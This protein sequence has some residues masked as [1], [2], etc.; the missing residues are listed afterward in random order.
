VLQG[1]CDGFRFECDG[2]VSVIF[3]LGPK[4]DFDINLNQIPDR[5]DP[6]V[7]SCQRMVTNSSYSD[8]NIETNRS[9]LSSTK[10]RAKIN[11]RA[12]SDLEFTI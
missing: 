4:H 3:C 2:A 12:V 11:K 1:N 10:R 7:L 9:T 6:F 5:R 8:M